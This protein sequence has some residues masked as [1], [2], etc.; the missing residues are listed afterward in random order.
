MLI[1][2]VDAHYVEPYNWLEQVDP[3]LSALIPYQ[4]ILESL[5][6]GT[7]AEMLAAVPEEHRPDLQSLIPEPGRQFLETIGKL[8]SAAA[9]EFIALNQGQ[10]AKPNY[11]PEHRLTGMDA[12]GV[13]LQLLHPNHAVQTLLYIKRGLPH[14][15]NR[16]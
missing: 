3:E 7:V 4:A 5:L 14:Y 13:N 11:L 16:V 10:M 6:T 12:Q 8:P 1:I 2:D 9:Q 15:T